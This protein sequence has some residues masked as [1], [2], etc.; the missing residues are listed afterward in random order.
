M[1]LWILSLALL[2]NSLWA[3][4]SS[5]GSSSGAGNPASEFCLKN[6]GKIET[7]TDAKGD[8]NNCRIEQWT[9][10][11]AFSNNGVDP[12]AF[13]GSFHFPDGSLDNPGIRLCV[14]A[15]GTAWNDVADD[16]GQTGM[17]DV[18][19]WTLFKILN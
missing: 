5:A 12:A 18:E 4:V 2:S 1:R 14:A 17:C 8:K 13:V 3:Q 9:L 19:E 7:V 10:W 16:G 15:K 6:G 11:R